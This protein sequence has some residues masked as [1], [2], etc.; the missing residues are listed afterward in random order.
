MKTK[1]TKQE[2]EINDE[3]AKLHNEQRSKLDAD[4]AQ[5]R[6]DIEKE[7]DALKQSQASELSRAKS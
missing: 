7:L 5:R 2:A 3:I 6:K 1:S 4:M